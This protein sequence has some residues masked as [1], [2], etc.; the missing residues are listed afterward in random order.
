MTKIPQPMTWLTPAAVRSRRPI[1]RTSTGRSP[2][3][4]TSSPLPSY[5]LCS[6]ACRAFPRGPV[7]TVAAAPMAPATALDRARARRSP[8]AGTSDRP[9]GVKERV[10]LRVVAAGSRAWRSPKTPL[11][12]AGGRLLG[13]GHE[14]GLLRLARGLW[15]RTTVADAGKT[16][17]IRRMSRYR[18]ERQFVLPDLGHWRRRA[19]TPRGRGGWNP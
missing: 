4:C 6:L 5:P 1:A 8:R 2:S 19:R 18:D 7:A 14:Y 3:A 9:P 13:T 11:A 15:R 10:L 17:E 16:S 12:V